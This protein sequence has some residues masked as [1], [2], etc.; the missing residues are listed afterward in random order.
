VNRLPMT[1]LLTLTLASAGCGSLFQ[2]K[3]APPTMYLLS[4]THKAADRADPL[5]VDLG[6]LKPRV[7]AGL[8]TDR[9][10]VLYPDRR[11]DYFANVRWSG[12]V[13]EVV[14]EL[15]IQEFRA[16]DA[17]RNVSGES[18]VFASSYWLEVEV[19]DFQAEYAAGA[20]V[21]AI[22]V[23]LV[24]R[25]GSTTDRRVMTRFDADAIEPAADNRMGAIA[26]AFNRAA[27]KAL[28]GI[29]ANSLETL[30]AR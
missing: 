27:D 29:V 4:M 21:P 12:P 19:T 11:L 13:D 9:I 23:H 8:D 15:A 3:A 6:V 24:G 2:T 20:A 10:A 17:V 22:H 5:P 25:I 18:S 28:S 14:Q 7:R 30:K 16:I 26:E 1:L